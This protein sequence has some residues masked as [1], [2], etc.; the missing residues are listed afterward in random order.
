MYG[1]WGNSQPQWDS[2]C[3]KVA[4]KT[5]IGASPIGSKFQH[6]DLSP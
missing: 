6:H 2:Q 3:I 4:K 1:V 5:G